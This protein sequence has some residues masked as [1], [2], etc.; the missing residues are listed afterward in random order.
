MTL[1]LGNVGVVA[2][3]HLPGVRSHT[4]HAYVGHWSYVARMWLRVS[5][6]GTC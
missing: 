6:T 2:G 1:N 5:G 3:E 4:R